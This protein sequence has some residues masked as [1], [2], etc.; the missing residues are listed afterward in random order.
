[1]GNIS[2][3]SLSSFGI[4]PVIGTFGQGY[5]QRGNRGINPFATHIPVSIIYIVIVFVR[6]PFTV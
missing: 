2:I 5:F 4:F 1:M 3:T 6:Q